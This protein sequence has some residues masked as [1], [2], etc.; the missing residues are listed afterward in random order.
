MRYMDIVKEEPKTELEEWKRR[1]N[2]I[3]AKT[4]IGFGK[5]IAVD[6]AI[7]CVIC[8][9]VTLQPPFNYTCSDECQGKSEYQADNWREE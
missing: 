3:R 2:D 4:I 5:K 6:S 7:M 8:N 1:I 9:T